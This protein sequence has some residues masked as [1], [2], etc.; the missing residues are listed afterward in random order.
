MSSGNH[1]PAVPGDPPGTT[2]PAAPHVAFAP[3]PSS[4]DLD[5][6]GASGTQR[7]AEL[8]V[9]SATRSLRLVRLVVAG[10]AADLGFTV[11]AVE[12]L[13]VAVDEACGA[14]M[15]SGPLD[16]GAHL[17]VAVDGAEDAEGHRLEVAVWSDPLVPPL[18]DAV[19]AL[20]LEHTTD[21]WQA[22]EGRLH[23]WRTGSV[24]R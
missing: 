24:L 7:L 5:L 22:T 15:S 11:D 8:R 2:D 1:P 16:R 17:H 9:P 3:D 18:V 4:P 21:G 12:D 13:R 23:F 14:V 20:L 19:P 6:R 10:A